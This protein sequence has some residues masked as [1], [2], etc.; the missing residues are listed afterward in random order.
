M[1][2]KSPLEL[3]AA[4]HGVSVEEVRQ[5]ISLAIQAAMES[6]SPQAREFWQ[7]V[8]KS[9]SAPS[10]DELVAFLARKLYERQAP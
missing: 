10:P 7:S 4:K 5:E 9:G 6:S 2:L 3:V 8:P 1:D